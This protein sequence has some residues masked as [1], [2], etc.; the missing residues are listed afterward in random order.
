LRKKAKIGLPKEARCE[1]CKAKKNLES[2]K[3]SMGKGG[4]SK[5]YSGGAGGYRE[6]ER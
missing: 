2:R 6:K 5:K 4:S 3:R 1:A